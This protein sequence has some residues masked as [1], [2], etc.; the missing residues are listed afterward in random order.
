MDWVRTVLVLAFGLVCNLVSDSVLA[1]PDETLIS[2]YR[3]GQLVDIAE[4]GR[5]LSGEKFV[6]VMWDNLRE[7]YEVNVT[8]AEDGEA[9]SADKLDLE[10][11]GSVWPN[12]GIGTYQPGWLQ[13]DD[14]WN[15]EWV[16]AAAKVVRDSG[17]NSLVFKF[18]PLSKKEWKRALP[19]Q[20]PTYRGTLKVRVVSKGDA[21]P[22]GCK[23]SVY[24]ES[25]W[26]EAS[27]DILSKQL[28]GRI[29]IIN[30]QLLDMS[31]LPAPHS[32]SVEGTNWSAEGEAAGVGIRV[33]YAETK[34]PHSNDLTRVTV[35]LGKAEWATGFSFVP[36]QVLKEGLMRLGSLGV[37]VAD[38]RVGL[39]KD[40]D[41]KRSDK[42][43]AKP[44]R[45][46]IPDRPEMTYESA[47]EGIPRLSPPMW[48]PIGVPSA[49]QEVFISPLGEWA[50][51]W[52]SLNPKGRKSAK[53]LFRQPYKVKRG[54]DQPGLY[55]QLDTSQE[56]KFDGKDREGIKRYL[57]ESCLPLMH[58]EWRRGPI[59]YHHQMASTILLGDIGDDLG[60]RGDETVV[61]LS[62]LEV[63]NTS[64]KPET[65]TLNL[66]YTHGAP[67]WLQ[68][69]GMVM[70]KPRVEIPSDMT[71]LRGQLSVDR[72]T[73]G[74]IDGW[75][76]EPS[77]KAMTSQILRWQSRLEPGQTQRLYFK[78][79]YVDLLEAKELQR[80]KEISY[81]KE[82]PKVLNYWRGRVAGGMQIEVP[83]RALNQFYAANLWHNLITTDRDVET[84]LYNQFVGTWGYMVFANETVMIA[85]SM[86]MRGEHVEAERYL[87]PILH[88]QG[89][90]PLT[91]NFSTKKDVLHGAG[92]Y[93]HGKYA[94]NHG[95]VLWGVADHYLLER[96][97]PKLVKGCDFLISERKATM[98]KPFGAD[99][100]VYGLAP[101]C[102]LEDIT[103]FKYW[104]ATNSYYYLGM[105]RVAQ[106]L[107]DI[108]HPESGRISL[109]AEKYRVD[110]ERALREATTRAAAVR[111]RDGSY[112]PQVPPRVYQ[113]QHFTG[114]WVR[115]ALYCSLHAAMAEVV[116]PDDP[117]MT[118]MLDELE[119]N[120][121]FSRMAGF[122]LKEVVPRRCD[123]FGIHM[124]CWFILS[125]SVWRSGRRIT[126][127]LAGRST[128]L[129]MSR[130]L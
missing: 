51:W 3:I 82:I 26:Q 124:R 7:V 24:G 108:D 84:G 35:R 55:V 52:P 91:G 40:A 97:A 48:I 104:F 90:E 6:G 74:G 14:H 53:C 33:L 69:D 89:S 13:K 75:S 60:R 39:G 34:N 102:A 27:F 66:R 11:W 101:A 100:L 119:D 98:A 22:K 78:Q 15:G 107:A 71:A 63:T 93:T 85:R 127:N 117:L 116:S 126:A 65:A 111:L 64:D 2:Q 76:L 77:I 96:V 38:S 128:R 62:K 5:P 49:E 42:D 59:R 25:R 106:A 68:E 23:L 54:G 80:L 110:I 67:L 122:G 83:D 43:L 30:G 44:V 9:P 87:E 12:V 32:V 41:I 70:I 21:L 50:M 120:I 19:K 36:Q 73:G 16:R 121:F 105:K 47:M 129:R 125:I 79:P 95:F 37:M 31:S 20:S 57:D 130:D 92:K 29:E 8:F 18:K 94:M 4:F 112:I 114:G 103:E 45:L 109:E 10:W 1:T 123:R 115:E 17:S 46:R 56:P 88:F 118:W 99:N 113:W 72:A 81:E 58:A 28:H 86:D 61:F